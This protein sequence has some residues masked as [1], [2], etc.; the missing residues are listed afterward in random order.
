M[1]CQLV[2]LRFVALALRSVALALRFVALA[3]RLAALALRL[4]ASVCLLECCAGSE[5]RNSEVRNSEVPLLG[6]S[7]GCFVSLVTAL[8]DKTRHSTTSTMEQ[9]IA[10][11]RMQACA[12]ANG[13]MRGVAGRDAP[14]ESRCGL[15]V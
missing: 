4:L 3:L 14:L 15:R 9:M 5:A 1:A 10:D 8:T 11:S 6:C 12:R 13:G 7:P 2:W